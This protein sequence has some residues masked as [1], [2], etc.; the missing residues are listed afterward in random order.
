MAFSNIVHLRKIPITAVLCII[1]KLDIKPG[2]AWIDESTSDGNPKGDVVPGIVDENERGIYVFVIDRH[3]S[4]GPGIANN[5]SANVE[6]NV[7]NCDTF[8]GSPSS[9]IAKIDTCFD[10]EYRYFMFHC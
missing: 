8:C 7:G 1:L 3:R 2:K 4:Y 6:R 9:G 10:G 5:I